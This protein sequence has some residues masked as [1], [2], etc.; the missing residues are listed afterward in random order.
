MNKIGERIAAVIKSL[1]IKK[2]EFAKRLNISQPYVSELCVG[3]TRPSD[4]TIYDICR[5]FK[6][7]EKWLR[8]GEGEMFLKPTK[9]EEL[10]DF[11][12]DILE[13]ESTDFRRRLIAALAK[14]DTEKW[15]V[16]EEIASTL[17]N[18]TKES[19]P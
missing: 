8:T 10:R 14:L 7:N 19:D 16:L 3:K 18:E 9:D 4:R 1:S 2:T 6:V 12:D 11:V 5:E 15:K 13:S 17:S